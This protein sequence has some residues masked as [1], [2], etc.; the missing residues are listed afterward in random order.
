[1]QIGKLA[2]TVERMYLQKM[3]RNRTGADSGGTESEVSETVNEAEV[4]LARAAGRVRTGYGHAQRP[5]PPP[6]SGDEGIL[7]RHRSNGQ[8]HQ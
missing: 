5:I 4:G 8:H 1:M 7:A 2:E 6:Q 3:S